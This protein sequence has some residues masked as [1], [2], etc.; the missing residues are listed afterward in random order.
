MYEN[1]RKIATG[2]EYI[3]WKQRQN[4]FYFFKSC[5]KK[6]NNYVMV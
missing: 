6:T 5:I 1:I 2:V 4:L 3:L